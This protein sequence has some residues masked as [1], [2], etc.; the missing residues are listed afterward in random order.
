M[1]FHVSGRGDEGLE[2]LLVAR[3]ELAD[4]LKPGFVGTLD[5]Y[6]AAAMVKYGPASDRGYD[7]LGRFLF[8][9]VPYAQTED[10]IVEHG[11]FLVGKP[12]GD[13]LPLVR[14]GSA[15]AASADASPLR[16]KGPARMHH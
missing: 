16:G 7:L 6:F 12:W 9:V 11:A 14:P 5:D 1:H 13:Q 2:T 8:E 10:G 15:G 3:S 4:L